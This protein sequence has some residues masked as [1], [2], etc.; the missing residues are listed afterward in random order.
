[1]LGLVGALVMTSCGSNS[2]QPS[3]TVTGTITVS[4]ASSLTEAFAKIGRNF[5]TAN[6]GA[7]VT[8]NFGP[9]STLKTQI[10][11]G[12]PAD[13]FASADV[14]NM[15]ELHIAGLLHGRSTVFA[16][17]R[18]VLVTKP[19]N[20]QQV[21]TLNDLANVGTISLCGRDVPCGRYAAQA[22][23]AAGVA[24]AETRITRGADAKATLAAVTTGD[25]DAAI[26]YATDAEAAGSSVATVR[27]PDA[28]NVT[29][30]YPIAALQGSARP[31]LALRFIRYVESPQGEATLRS[32]GFLPPR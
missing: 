9:S 28:R 30:V 27:L 20:P 29:A 11:Q 31:A 8:F 26:V 15:H 32:F 25:A 14:E 4:A 17:N 19:G 18:L 6:P 16:K 12:A 22:F 24:I 23:R 21:E 10:V 13:V 1:M 7:S 3:S 5:E 2:S